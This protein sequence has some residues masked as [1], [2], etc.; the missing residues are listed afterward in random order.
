MTG[1]ERL[2]ERK[3]RDQASEK[4]ERIYNNLHQACPAPAATDALAKD[5]D[6]SGKR[7]CSKKRERNRTGTYDSRTR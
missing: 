3:E 6:K 4:A 7:E 1:A 5:G 2:P